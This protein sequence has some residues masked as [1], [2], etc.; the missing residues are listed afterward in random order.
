MGVVLVGEDGL[1]PLHGAAGGVA[2]AEPGQAEREQQIAVLAP[3]A[4]RARGE[5]VLP[6]RPI[7]SRAFSAMF[8]SHCAD[9]A[10]ALAGRR[11]GEAQEARQ[12][13]LGPQPVLVQPFQQAVARPRQGQHVAARQPHQVRPRQPHRPHRQQPL[14]RL[15]EALHVIEPFAGSPAAAIRGDPTTRRRRPGA[16]V[17]G[18]RLRPGQHRSSSSAVISRPL[19]AAVE[20]RDGP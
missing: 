10:E 12:V 18:R 4:G 14:V 7:H 6:C 17:R 20:R 11:A 5:R 2:L 9:A 13:L 16:Q 3:S 19:P 15:Q 1:G 8:R